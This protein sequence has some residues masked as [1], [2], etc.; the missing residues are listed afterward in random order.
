MKLGTRKV[1]IGGLTAVAFTSLTAFTSVTP[2]TTSEINLTNVT[3]S[4]VCQNLAVAEYISTSGYGIDMAALFM[5][6]QVK[7]SKNTKTAQVKSGS[8]GEKSAVNAQAGV[9]KVFTQ[10]NTL[11]DLGSNS[12]E[13][14]AKAEAVNKT[15]LGST[16]DD[17]QNDEAVQNDALEADKVQEDSSEDT[18]IEEADTAEVNNGELAEEANTGEKNTDAS[19]EED[20]DKEADENKSS[21]KD[22]AEDKE[23]ADKEAADKEE[24]KDSE[25]DNSKEAADEK[26]GEE[27]SEEMKAN[28][29]ALEEEKEASEWSERVM[30]D[31][32]E[33]V[34]I[35]AEANEEGEII[36][37]LYKGA[38]ADIIEKGDEWTKI[39]SG[40]IDEGYVKNDYLAFDEDAEAL[41]EQEGRLVA[42]VETD[43]LRI[44]SEASE[45]GAILD[46]A[47]NG[48]DLT[49][50][51][52]EGDW[53][54][55]A[56]TEEK[57]AFV[58]KDFVSVEYVLGEAITIAE[59]EAIRAEK[60]RQEA[61]A[62]KAEIAA[63]EEA[64][65][66]AALVK[67]EAGG[68]SYEGKL[69]VA[70]VV[71]NRVRSG[72][73]PNSVSGVIYQ[74]G[75]FPGAG[76]GTLAS[77][78]ASGAGGDN[79]RAAVEALSGATNVSYLHFNSVS[80]IGTGGHVIG[81]HCF[82]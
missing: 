51:A 24:N 2:D 61:E 47:E 77:I 4:I 35:R 79:K 41:A 53:V 62:R 63:S 74:S 54:E 49:A 52:E 78:I 18:V 6:G 39:R 64:A 9:A 20:A 69:A 21:D 76:N 29:K 7:I 33:S 70:S 11:E 60:A 5:P 30:A 80:R 45:E 55:I 37:K 42:T 68:E 28:E 40:A 46:L 27:A 13:A 71:V 17:V 50:V 14:Y 38:A 73:Y 8:V 81:N 57:T 31:V 66:L 75:Q 12:A 67:M 15:V 43:A 10:S 82:Y 48:Q 59:E 32:E 65:L 22:E 19:I 3:P 25:E 26:S 1:V 16:S 56:Y 58:A 44:R 34:N 36:G 72:G 23:S